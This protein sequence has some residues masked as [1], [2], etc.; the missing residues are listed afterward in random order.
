MFGSRISVEAT[1]KLPGWETPHAQTVA[2]SH[3]VKDM[4]KNALRDIANWRTK[5]QSSFSKFQVLARMII[6]SRQ[7]NS[8]LLENCQKFV[9]KLS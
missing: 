8:K 2:W 3:D 1:E 9:H 6:N 5:R 4:L 7:R